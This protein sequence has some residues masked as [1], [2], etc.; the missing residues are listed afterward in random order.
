MDTPLLPS[1]RNF[2]THIGSLGIG[3]ET[4]AILDDIRF[5]LQ[6]VIYQ[7]DP[8]PEPLDVDDG[9]KLATTAKWVC[10]RITSLGNPLDQ[11]LS[12]DFIYQS[13]RKVALIYCQAIIERTP[14]S[15]SCTTQDLSQLW[16]A[17][18][19]ITLTQ[20]K[21]IPGIFIWILLS[22]NQAAQETQH[23]R[24]IKSL[25]KS[26][27]FYVALENWEVIDGSLAAFVKLQRWLKEKSALEESAETLDSLVA[28]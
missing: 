10:D 28:D 12:Q 14:L 17:V 3:E 25:L 8:D 4:A 27:S 9:G 19:R 21:K 6:A 22:V 2:V 24:L 1:S 13:C 11:T 18:W 26:A 7:T 15:R 23:G 20:W 5:L 16:A